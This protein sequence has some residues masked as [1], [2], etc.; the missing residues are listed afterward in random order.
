MEAASLG[1]NMKRHGYRIL[2]YLDFYTLRSG[3]SRLLGS[4]ANQGYLAIRF[5]GAKVLIILLLDF[6]KSSFFSLFI[7]KFHIVSDGLLSTVIL[8]QRRGN[9][10]LET[11]KGS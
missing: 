2:I 8:E 10:H 7:L 4:S 3:L 11:C 5:P 6:R 9:F 1:V